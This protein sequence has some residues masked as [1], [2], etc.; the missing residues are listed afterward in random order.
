MTKQHNYTFILYSLFFILFASAAAEAQVL[1][2]RTRLV[3][4]ERQKA[5]HRAKSQ[6]ATDRTET[7]TVA[8]LVRCNDALDLAALERK[9]AAINGDRT[10]STHILSIDIPIDSLAALEHV[11]GV[12]FV[13]IANRAN[14]HFDTARKMTGINDLHQRTTPDGTPYKG[15]G[16]IVGIVDT[17]LEYAHPAFLNADGSLRIKRAWNQNQNGKAPKG[18]SYGAEYTTEAELRAA[19]F[20]TAESYHA[21]HVTNIAAGSETSDYY[22]TASQAELV[23]VSTDTKDA[24]ITDAVKYIFDYADSMG[25]PCVINMSLGLHVGPHDGT[26]LID[27]QLDSYA[28]PGHIIVGSAG[29][30]GSFKMHVSKLFAEGDTSLKT[31]LGYQS[32]TADKTTYIDIWGNDDANLRVRVAVMDVFKGKIVAES[33]TFTC[34]DPLG[35][36]IFN[37]ETG[38][39]CLF[40]I[41]PM[42]L[43]ENGRPEFFI[44]S[45]V[46]TLSDA[47]KL[48][49]IVE[50]DPGDEVH[51]WNVLGNDFVSGNLSGFTDGDNSCTVGEVGGTARNIIS[52]GSYNSRSSYHAWWMEPGMVVDYSSAIDM[53]IGKTSS[54]SSLGPTADGRIK[55]D[56]MAPG[57]LVISAVNKHWY[58]FDASVTADRLQNDAGEYFYYDVEAGT[59]MSSPCVAGIVAT[60]LQARPQMTPDEVREVIRV[61]AKH[62]INTP[63][64]PNNTTGYG[65]I[66]ASVGLTEVLRL[67]DL[68]GIESLAP[69]A[70]DT[71][72]WLDAACSL[73]VISP[74]AATLTV[75]APSGAVVHSESIASGHASVDLSALHPGVYIATVTTAKGNTSVRLL[76]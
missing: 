9:G 40:T 19:V 52:V 58:Q 39:D 18:Y 49:V 10:P 46:T 53:P 26:S 72:L 57:M 59:S 25:K 21:T 61:T 48:A 33:K 28:G 3:L 69:G 70:S 4:A 50:G 56:V 71:R 11:E 43:S 31:L 55:P 16:V 13:R 45:K 34:T 73:Q 30:E 17:G 66:N 62:D 27:R 6:D 32:G 8:A 65:K 60:W 23:F 42:R 15:E 64:Q 63:R 47:R 2:P 54:F 22:G 76:R 20:D 14:L 29:N 7:E 38:A 36:A 68:D 35:Y 41:T 74:T 51:A 37:S 67:N 44:E 12:E 24:H 75:V 1:S 5:V